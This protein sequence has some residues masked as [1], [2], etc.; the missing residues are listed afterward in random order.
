MCLLQL[1]LSKADSIGV[2]SEAL[3]SVAELN[4]RFPQ[5]KIT[6]LIGRG[7]MGAIYQA[8]QTS[9]DR[10]V[11]LKLIAK[12]VSQDPT[13]VERF[14]REAKTLAKLSH[15]N[16]VTIYD[17]GYS[18]DGMA[19]LIMEYMDGINLREA[20]KSR[21]VGP[22]DALDIVATI[23]RALEYAHSRGVIHRDIKPENIL[24]GE[25]GSLKVV[26][27]GIAKIVD[28]SVRTPTLTAT[29][30]VLGSLHYLAPEQIESPDQVDH[31]V[32]LYA[33]G[34]VFYELL[35]GELP[36]GRYDPPSALLKHAD[37]RLDSVVLKSLSR[38][39]VNRFQTAGEFGTEVQQ[40]KSFQ[41][42]V[43][44]QA[45][46]LPPPIPGAQADPSQPVS[47]PF[48]CD[49]PFTYDTFGGFAEAIGMVYANESSLCIEFRTRDKMMGVLKS[50][51]HL[52][53][54]PFGKIT[55]CE[56]MCG[57]F[58]TKMVISVNSLSLLYKLP[59]SEAGFVELHVKRSD[60]PGAKRLLNAIGFGKNDNIQ[61]IFGTE[62]YTRQSIFGGLMI[63]SGIANLGGL[64]IGQ[65]LNANAAHTSSATVAIGA[66]VLAV[67][68]GPVG[69]MQFVGGIMNF[70]LPMKPLNGVL[71]VISL[72]PIAPA[73]LL[74]LPA[75]I[76]A[77]P[78]M[79]GK[80]T[81][82]NQQPAWGT[83][84]LMF[85]R[86]SRWS[87]TI[88]GANA[89]GLAIVGLLA[90]AYMGGFY[91]TSIAYRIVSDGS[92]SSQ[93]ISQRI[94]SRVGEFAPNSKLQFNDEV[95]RLKISDWRC[96][97]ENIKAALA[98]K[99]QLQLAWLAAND[100]QLDSDS[101]S[102]PLAGK[103]SVDSLAKGMNGLSTTVLTGKP[104][105]DL[106]TEMV[107]AIESG[108]SRSISIELS[109]VGRER[110]A[111]LRGAESKGA[112]GLVI[113]GLIEGVAGTDA[114]SN[115]RV[116]FELCEQSEFSPASI[117]A[118]IWGPVL[119][120]ELEWVQ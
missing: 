93:D 113:G 100:A 14:E 91:P 97:Q 67:L 85:I 72:L 120:C 64:A 36:L 43:D 1:G 114:I 32:D 2:S 66:I 33:L 57:M 52:I 63:L 60:I 99:G 56:L 26:D 10:D 40:L 53:E 15:P 11:A 19:Y 35:T 62:T 80:L 117:K 88:A 76:W 17:F 18:T 50:R 98:I 112:I 41:S 107:G 68:I 5:L 81:E 101:V 23:C 34:V 42:V 77:S 65:V 3:P 12:E 54:I 119:P 61:P 94:R 90:A 13:F 89:V 55:R 116:E 48:N 83:T 69:L 45:A 104:L 75:A 22:D 115:K 103:L 29:R 20:M 46:P 74:S 4:S 51:L 70:F 111:T 49:F 78:W 28:D 44:S 102:L 37:K 92:V 25:D 47:I 21:S 8:R 38:K 79:H 82:S 109:A 118:A 31:R 86:E 95:S 30:Q 24:L 96:N 106:T 58:S 84:T 71:T 105:I 59:N 39:P 27:F 9:L 7:G 6:R 87:K 73:W 16:I 110:L 108:Q